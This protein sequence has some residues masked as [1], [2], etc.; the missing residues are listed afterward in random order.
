MVTGTYSRP[1]GEPVANAAVMIEPLLV[2]ALHNGRVQ[3]I[4]PFNVL[5]DGTGALSLPLAPG[6]YRIIFGREYKFIIN[7][8]TDTQTAVLNDLVEK[9]A[10]NA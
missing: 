2:D 3:S 6:R 4:V 10:A 8:P 7:V 9:E 5:T 1:D